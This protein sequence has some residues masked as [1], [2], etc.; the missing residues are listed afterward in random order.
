M[1]TAAEFVPRYTVEDYQLWEG[2]WELW[3]GIAVAMTP[4]PFGR[5]AKLLAQLARTLGN[6]IEAAQCSATVL[7]ELDWLVSRTT[8]LRPDLT[9]V[10]GDAPERHVEEPPALVAE[11]L[12]AT[13]RE[14]DLSMKK[15]IYR[16]QA[17]SWY[18]IVDPD[19]STIAA[20]R[21]NEGGRFEEVAD[22]EPIV[23]DLCENCRIEFSESQL[24]R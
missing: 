3:D 1:S 5:H 18:L 13:T 17:V 16:Q 24:F 7:V 2:D 6:A 9:V 11:I 23:I 12:S 21:L 10:C 19:A 15:E 4:S 20:Y 14:R 8:V 22:R